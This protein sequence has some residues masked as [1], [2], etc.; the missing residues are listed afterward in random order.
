M[1]FEKKIM[2]YPN[3]EK[4]F[5]TMHHQRKENWLNYVNLRKL[6]KDDKGVES[7]FEGLGMK[8]R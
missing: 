5:D 1:N 6:E 2:I 4:Y 8:K 3:V 7:T